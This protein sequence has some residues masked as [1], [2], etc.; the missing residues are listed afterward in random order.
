MNNQTIEEKLKETLHQARID[1]ILPILIDFNE[2]HN[3]NKTEFH[4]L[5]IN[6]VILPDN[7]KVLEIYE[8]MLFIWYDEMSTCISIDNIQELYYWNGDTNI[9]VNFN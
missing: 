4:S 9:L 2:R 1:A 7:I 8:D 5:S 3:T 6:N